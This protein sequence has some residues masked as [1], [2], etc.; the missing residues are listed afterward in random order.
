M[1]KVIEKIKK[2]SILNKIKSIAANAEIYAVGGTVR[3]F[4]LGENNFDK[5]IIVNKIEAKKFAQD[6][7]KTFEGTF[8]PLDEENKIYRIVLPDKVNY[9]DVANLIG[10]DIKEDLKRR[11][12]TINSIGIDLKTYE[13]LDFTGGLE[14]LKKKKIKHIS[15]KNLIDDPLRILR[16]FRFNATLGFKIDKE[17]LLLCKKHS[18]DIKKSAQ[19]RITYEILKLFGGKFSHLSIEL[20]DEA[21]LLEIVLPQTKELKMVPHNS[22]HHLNLFMHSIETVKQIQ[23]I[24]KESSAEV[25]QHL[26]KIDFGGTSRLAHLKLAGFL[27]DVGKFSTW[28]IE[29]ETGKHRFIKHDDVGAKMI[30]NDLK[31]AKFSKKQIEYVSKMIK[32]HIYPSHVVCSSDSNEKSHMRLIRKMNNDVIDIITLAKADRYSARGVE[33]TDEIVHNNISRLNSLLEFYLNVRDSLKPLPKLLSGEEVM[34]ILN[35]KPS[36]E[37]GIIIK[38]LQEAQVSGEVCTKEEALEFIKS[39]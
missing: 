5:D 1:N 25:K 29:E 36:K 38:A 34:K 19:E 30:Q 3:D 10:D 21:G 7:A 27:H 11:D 17:T 26:E 35:L 16:A 33:I 8:I 2:D 22:H 12:L 32:Y 20:M 18:S 14:D 23:K 28:T 15:E 37:L 4:F 6:L 31:K 39:R 9:I 13:I 24:Y